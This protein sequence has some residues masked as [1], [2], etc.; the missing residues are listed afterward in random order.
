MLTFFGIAGIHDHS[1]PLYTL[2]DALHL[3][4]HLLS[5]LERV[6]QHA[7]PGAARPVRIV[8][9]GGGP[10]GVETAG[11]LTSMAHE[12]VGPV[13]DLAVTLVEAGPRLLSGFSPR[14]SQ[15][16]LIDLCRRGVDVRLGQS[17]TAADAQGVTLRAC[18]QMLLVV[19]TRG[20]R[21][22]RF[23]DGGV[24]CQA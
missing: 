18:W 1:W 19:F 5:T 20:D 7:G 22:W 16:A 9:V 8:V 23:G 24:S 15:R 10:T 2:S 11:A 21:W 14:S 6:A 12:V 3:R 17:V 13:A 4:R